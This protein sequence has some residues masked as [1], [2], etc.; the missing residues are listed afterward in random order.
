MKLDFFTL[1]AV[2]LGVVMAPA[3]IARD[4][5]TAPPAPLRVLIVTGINNHD[6][7]AT[8]PVLKEILD[9][10]GRFS[11]RVVT[12]PATVDAGTFSD[13]DVVLSNFNTHGKKLEGPLWGDETRIAFEKWILAGGGFV[14]VHAGSSMFHDWAGFQKIACGTWRNGTRHGQRH[15]NKVSFLQLDHPITRGL[16]EFYTFDEFWENLCV[17]PAALALATV[18]PDPAFRGSG[19]PEPVVLTTEWGKGRGFYLVLGH[20]I[21]AMQNVGFR[22]LLARGVEWAGSGMVT[23]PA[24]APWP[25]S[26]EDVPH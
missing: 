15:V 14:N 16:G 6:W 12:D 8:T 2:L 11:V 21:K 7:K 24:A 5:A 1:I 26:R 10:S 3:G 23:L 18:T 22:S 25:G 19:K 13:V 17:D 4:P 20:D 9:A